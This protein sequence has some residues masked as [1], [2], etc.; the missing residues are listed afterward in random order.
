MQQ[1]LCKHDVNCSLYPKLF[2]NLLCLIFHPDDHHCLL[3]S[4]GSLVGVSRLREEMN[5]CLS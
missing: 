3:I 1:D 5:R 4:V 2:W